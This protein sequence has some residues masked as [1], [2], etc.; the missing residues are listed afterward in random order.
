[1]ELAIKSFAEK[2]FKQYC[3]KMSDANYIPEKR[4]ALPQEAFMVAPMLH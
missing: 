2:L 4:L 1:L 3:F